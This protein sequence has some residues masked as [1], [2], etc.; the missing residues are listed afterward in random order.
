MTKKIIGV[1]VGEGNR[2]AHSYVLGELTK[3]RTYP[4]RERERICERK[5]D[6]E[7]QWQGKITK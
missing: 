4:Y 2:L 1:G 6:V 7:E 3:T 5:Q